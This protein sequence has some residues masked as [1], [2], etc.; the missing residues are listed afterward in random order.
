[1][2]PRASLARSAFFGSRRHFPARFSIS[3]FVACVLVEQLIC[4]YR[5]GIYGYV[6][7]LAYARR[8]VTTASYM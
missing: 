8:L 1:M 2:L 7:A 6:H 5:V 4:S 3:S